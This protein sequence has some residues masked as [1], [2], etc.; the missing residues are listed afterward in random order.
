MKGRVRLKPKALLRAFCC[1]LSL[2]FAL[3]AVPGSA[4]AAEKLVL[5]LSG[6][7][8][9]RF[10]GY[11]A[12]LWQGFYRKAGLDV[13]IRPGSVGGAATP[14][15]P[16]RE[17]VEG[18]AQFGIG[19]SDLLVRASEGLPLLL[20]AP[21]FQESAARVYYRADTDFSS[22]VALWSATIGRLPA[23]SFL[24]LEL[25]SA[26]RA[27]GIDADKLRARA[28]KR[29][30]A[31]GELQEKKIDAA[32]A[33]A[34]NLPW[35]AKDRGVALKSFDPA[36]Y[37][38]AFYG[39]S[40][41]TVAPWAE[42]N[43]Q[44]TKRFRAASLEGWAY[45]L[46]HPQAI[47][48][49]LTQNPPAASGKAG[50]PGGGFDFAVY[51]AALA[52]K[53]SAY[54]AIPLGHSNPHRWRR[55]E[56]NLARSGAI[57]RPVALGG[58]LYQGEAAAAEGNGEF[59]L[60]ILGAALLFLLALALFLVARR[61]PAFLPPALA[62]RFEERQR[63]QGLARNAV[64]IGAELSEIAERI[65]AP[66]DRFV[67][68]AAAE[69]HLARLRETAGGGVERLRALIRRLS[70]FHEPVRPEP[71]PSNLNAALTPLVAAIRHRIPA[72]MSCRL[73]LVPEPWL[74]EADAEAVAQSVL[75]LAVAAAAEMK[76]GGEIILGTRQFAIDRKTAKE[77]PG[78]APGDYVRV[79][80]RD[81][82]PGLSPERFEGVFDWEVTTRPAAAAAADMARRRGGF[83]RVETAEGVGTAVH[84]YF[85]K[86]AKEASPPQSPAAK[87]AE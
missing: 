73:S 52:Q 5:Q 83:A 48:K 81:N 2:A 60:V 36:D 77:W 37:R 50:A 29:G 6:P 35:Q 43:G 25:K 49:R 18:R 10:A 69:P 38:V 1:G 27:E 42:A 51:Q 54:P 84:L 32:I 65:A 8:Q 30:E 47:A 78:S 68:E 86:S 14:I 72:G 12:A 4:A 41:F 34:W 31:L 67:R 62:R 59:G 70:A 22:P 46:K 9:F 26:L 24:D 16:V 61:R 53:L 74:C 33:S 23:S 15:D 17:V 87:A 80:V 21:V 64:Q 76:E 13:A 63:E 66:L 11:Y 82:G 58:F 45:A 44:T 20:L 40:L 39:D 75:D 55:I 28:I 79:T 71:E 57:L 3:P 19:G 85:R 56:E 7:R